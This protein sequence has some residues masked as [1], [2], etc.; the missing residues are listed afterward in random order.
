GPSNPVEK[1][2][3]FGSLLPA[4][5]SIGVSTS[6]TLR[7]A[8]KARMVALTSARSRS[9]SI[10]AVGCHELMA[11]ILRYKPPSRRTAGESA[12][13]V[14]EGEQLRL[15]PDRHAQRVRLVQLGAG[16]FAGDHEAGLLRHAAG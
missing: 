12:E 8:K 5:D 2:M 6:S 10:S 9:A 15:V 14:E 13:A 3:M 7:S 11:G 1:L 16:R 4:C